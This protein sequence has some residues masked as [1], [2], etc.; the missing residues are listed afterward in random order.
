MQQLNDTEV[1]PEQLHIL[2]LKQLELKDK[3]LKQMQ[4]NHPVMTTNAFK[5]HTEKRLTSNSSGLQ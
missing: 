3:L 4:Q 1:L 2:T 5:R